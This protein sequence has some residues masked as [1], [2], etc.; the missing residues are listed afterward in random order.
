MSDQPAPGSPVPAE[1]RRA[2]RAAAA[3]VL[4]SL[5]S[6]LTAA[7]IPMRQLLQAALR[8]AADEGL[9]AAASVLR[10]TEHEHWAAALRR[11]TQWFTDSHGMRICG[12][13][14]SRW[15]CPDADLLAAAPDSQH[16]KPVSPIKP[17]I[18]S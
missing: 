1:A 13:C 7:Q 8:L 6:D 18:H 15:P 17:G 9:E 2:A 12:G 10:A 5:L 14:L 11:H 16:R 3:T 4:P